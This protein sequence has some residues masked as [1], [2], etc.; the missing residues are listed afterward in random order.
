MA[1]RA[2]PGVRIRES[3]S[4]AKLMSSNIAYALVLYTL[5]LIFLVA[6]QME[7]KGMSI[8][9]YFTLVALV[10][11]VILP[12]RNLERRWNALDERALPETR[13]LFWRDAIFLWVFAIGI[14]AA[15]AL[16]LWIIP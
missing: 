13:R 1:S 2:E 7:S 10:A 11:A 5:V 12:C 15:L 8:L 16:L 3:A 9:P 14:P 4:Y 6:P